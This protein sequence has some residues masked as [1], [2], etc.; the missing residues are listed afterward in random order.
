MVVDPESD[1]MRLDRFVAMRRKRVSRARAARLEVGGV[2]D[3][4]TITF[5]HRDALPVPA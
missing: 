4:P 2:E 1:G 5:P 3:E